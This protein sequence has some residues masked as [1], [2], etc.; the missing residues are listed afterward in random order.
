MASWAREME[1]L[2]QAFARR[3][4]SF[5]DVLA[6][7][8]DA[9]SQA[10][11][12]AQ[13]AET[14][15]AQ[16]EATPDDAQGLADFALLSRQYEAALQRIDAHQQA[17][18]ATALQIAELRESVARERA[19]IAQFQQESSAHTR[20]QLGR[21]DA[22]R[23][24]LQNQH[25]RAVQFLHERAKLV[26]EEAAEARRVRDKQQDAQLEQARE[27]ARANEAE[28]AE[29]LRLMHVALVEVEDRVQSMQAVLALRRQEH[30]EE[31]ER[32]Q[33]VLVEERSAARTSADALLRAHAAALDQVKSD[34]A[35]QDALS[36]S[37]IEAL[38]LNLS[39]VGTQLLAM[40]GAKETMALEMQS[41]GEAFFA[42]T[43]TWQHKLEERA[44]SLRAA[45]LLL[46]ALQAGRDAKAAQAAALTTRL[47]R[48]SLRHQRAVGRSLRYRESLSHARQAELAR[49][50]QHVVQAAHTQQLELR[51]TDGHRDREGREGELAT[52]QAKARQVDEERLRLAARLGSTEVLLQQVALLRRSSIGAALHRAVHGELARA[53]SAAGWLEH[54][55]EIVFLE[56]YNVNADVTSL[57]EPLVPAHVQTLLA[58]PGSE[59]VDTTYRT[60]LGREAD[61]EGRTFFCQRLLEGVGKL[62]IL[63]EFA[64]SPE[65]RAHGAS[66]P[67][68]APA[69]QHQGVQLGGWR[70][71]LLRWLG[72]FGRD[73]EV[74]TRLNR[75]EARADVDRLAVRQ[76]AAILVRQL[77]EIQRL[78]ADTV[79][80]LAAITDD[81][82]RSVGA[83]NRLCADVAALRTLALGGNIPEHKRS[84]QRS[85]LETMAIDERAGVGA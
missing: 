52:L 63:R 36:R 17:D 71:R 21:L 85:P 54:T 58:L 11:S 2:N 14:A 7:A 20:W 13:A 3:E 59:F 1:A 43:A 51:L 57:T 32:I 27:A 38:R 33:R 41:R 8:R 15:L 39:D 18:A 76:Q 56:E 50:Q 25:E 47:E 81:A 68:L 80:R 16:S 9:L 44:A 4:K 77:Q 60:L 37:K 26:E 48:E 53:Q 10:R 67:G 61:P 72:V 30:G 74:Q 29:K 46:S 28:F 5:L 6:T 62:Q 55:D 70:A 69:I 24:L 34:A 22:E 66:L 73:T 12:A 82:Q 23:V 78:H 42:A 65:A 84:S 40:T 35:R 79:S 64:E 75:A 49:E 45:N 19:F 83:M 31:I